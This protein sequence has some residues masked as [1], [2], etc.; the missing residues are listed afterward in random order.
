[1]EQVAQHAG[2]HGL[3]HAVGVD[4]A[5]LAQA[6][7]HRAAAAVARRSS[8]LRGISTMVAL[9]SSPEW[10]PRRWRWLRA[11]RTGGGRSPLGGGDRVAP[12]MAAQHGCV[13]ETQVHRPHRDADSLRAAADGRAQAAAEDA[14][15]GLGLG[16]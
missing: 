1:V 7:H 3:G 14:R 2:A 11:P 6:D 5:H 10:M 8:R 4:A 12:V 9:P 16:G 15:G 13:Q